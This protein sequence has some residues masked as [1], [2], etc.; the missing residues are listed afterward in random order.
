MWNNILFRMTEMMN[1][2]NN[3]DG[4][5]HCAALICGKQIISMKLNDLAA[6]AEVN[7]ICRMAKRW[8][9]KEAPGVDSNKI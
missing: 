8:W 1:K 6:H 2:A 5:W 9:E 7:V 4:R 3:A